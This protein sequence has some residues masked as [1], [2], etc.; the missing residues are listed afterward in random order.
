M[1]IEAWT[2]E[3]NGRRN[4]ESI[5]LPAF[6]IPIPIVSSFPL[7]PPSPPL[8]PLRYNRIGKMYK[9]ITGLLVPCCKSWPIREGGERKEKKRRCATNKLDVKREQ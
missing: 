8:S 7:P 2:G 5:N 9:F 4:N 6:V 3:E 1:V